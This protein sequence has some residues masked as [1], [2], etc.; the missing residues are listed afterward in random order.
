MLCDKQFSSAWPGVCFDGQ[1]VAFHVK[2][3][4]VC[5]PMCQPASLRTVSVVSLLSLSFI[6]LRQFHCHRVCL[7]G[8]F[9]DQF[10]NVPLWCQNCKHE[11]RWPRNKSHHYTFPESLV[12]RLCQNWFSLTK[13][14]LKPFDQA[15]CLPTCVMC[16]HNVCKD[17][18]CV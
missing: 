12:P 18:N 9:G 4:W 13:V 15:L 7:R 16:V 17:N 10:V 1:K 6:L 14:H 5:N 11:N 8:L 3:K 2:R